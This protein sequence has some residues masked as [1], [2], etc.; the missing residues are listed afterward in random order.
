[1]GLDIALEAFAELRRKSHSF[2]EEAEF[3]VSDMLVGSVLDFTLVSLMAPAAK[4][5]GLSPAAAVL[6][7]GGR[8]AKLRAAAAELP[9]SLFCAAPL[10]VRYTLTQRAFGFALQS[11][12]FAAVGAAC[13]LIGQ[14]MANTAAH[15]RANI[16]RKQ[17]PAYAKSA[18][19]LIMPPL[20][21]T[22]LVW[23]LFMGTSANVRLQ[24][25]VG[26][27]RLVESL[28][29]S[30]RVRALPLTAT[31]LLRFVNNVVGGEQFCDLARWAGVQ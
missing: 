29:V 24:G 25:V 11:V 13:G 15:A 27:E 16:R 20:P 26:I 4:L 23:G 17:D 6:A 8:L 7:R 31:F 10:G 30:R 9:C 18:A 2:W 12:R 28:A 3:F 5:G 1:M 21:R 19:T 14:A 22:A